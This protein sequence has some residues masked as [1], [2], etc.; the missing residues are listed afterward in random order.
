MLFDYHDFVEDSLIIISS[1]SYDIQKHFSIVITKRIVNQL[2]M[3]E[4][5]CVTIIKSNIYL[6]IKVL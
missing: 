4:Y 3:S 5:K 6:L 2:I 1:D